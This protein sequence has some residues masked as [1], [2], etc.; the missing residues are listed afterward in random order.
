MLKQIDHIGI[1]VRSIN[2]ALKVYSGLFG[3]KPSGEEIIESRGIKVCFLKIGDVK[4]ELLEPIRADSEISKHLEKKGEGMHHIA[5]CVDSVQEM[6]DKAKE[7]NLIPLS[8]TPKLGAHNTSVVFM[9]PK[10]TNGVLTEIL[11][12]N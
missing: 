3:I 12:H 2:D 6:I 10:S 4:I 9:H 11:Q 7:L 5:Y 1:A 8:D